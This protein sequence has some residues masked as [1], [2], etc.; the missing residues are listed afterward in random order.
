MPY[1]R[2][3]SEMPFNCGEN[4]WTRALDASGARISAKNRRERLPPFPWKSFRFVVPF[5]QRASL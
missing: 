2:V 3:S 1:V 4:A 5:R